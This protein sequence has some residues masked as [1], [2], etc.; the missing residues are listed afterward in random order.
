M[1][2]SFSSHQPSLQATHSN[3][4]A[5]ALTSTQFDPPRQ[6]SRILTHY[7]REPQLVMIEG[8]GILQ[9]EMDESRL[10]SKYLNVPFARVQDQFQ[11]A[12]APE[13]WKGIRDATLYGPMCPQNIQ[14]TNSLSTMMLGLPGPGFEYS[15]RDCLNL[16]VFAPRCVEDVPVICYI[17]GGLSQGGIALPKHDA[18]NI[19]KKSVARDRPVIVVT[20]NYRLLPS[21]GLLRGPPKHGDK[22]HKDEEDDDATFNWGLYDQ[23]IA[24]EWVRK[25]IHN[26]GGN[27]NE[28]TLMGHS[29]GESLAGYHMLTTTTATSTA[30]STKRDETMGR[31]FK[32]AIMHSGAV[33]AA[34][35]RS[36]TNDVQGEEATHPL[37]SRLGDMA[38]VG[39]SASSASSLA[40]RNVS[41]QDQNKDR[42]GQTPTAAATFTFMSDACLPHMDEREKQAGWRVID[43]WIDFAWGQEGDSADANAGAS[44]SS[45]HPA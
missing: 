8:Y 39:S 35:T 11:Q 42:H 20:I 13:P 14:E 36:A 31:L 37:S 9:G 45:V 22:N 10:L 26:F 4:N 34:S 5:N 24:L 23:K 43:R 32:R 44:A 3:N 21:A 33:A 17:H 25:H 18:T 7:C 2:R 19:V 1:S 38:T 29:N 30:T 41:G 6:I 27:P 16:N 40:V 28:I 15:E 12:V